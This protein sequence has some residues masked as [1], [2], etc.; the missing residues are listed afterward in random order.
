M[1]ACDGFEAAQNYLLCWQTIHKKSDSRYIYENELDKACFQHIMTY[2]DF[3]DQ[4]SQTES[5]KVLRDKA[6]YIVSNPEYDKYQHGLASIVYK[7]FD[8]NARQ[9]GRGIAK[10]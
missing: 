10:N 2:G 9:I 8:D 6:F 3:K 7:S 4:P 1:P 5:D